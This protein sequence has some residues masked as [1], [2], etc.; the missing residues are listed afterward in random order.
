MEREI[1]E[2]ELVSEIQEKLGYTL[3]IILKKM[4]KR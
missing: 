4:L 2:N 1:R 3:N